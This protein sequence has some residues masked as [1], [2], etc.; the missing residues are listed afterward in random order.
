MCFSAEIAVFVTRRDG[1]V[2]LL[3]RAESDGGY[4]HVVAGAIEGGE[5]ALSAAERE[6]REETGLVARLERCAEVMER[7]RRP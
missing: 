3:R 4:W 7:A 5:S 1:E 6:L 2:L